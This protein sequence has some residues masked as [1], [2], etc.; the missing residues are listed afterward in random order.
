MTLQA[1]PSASAV[2]CGTAQATITRGMAE[3]GLAPPAAAW[4]APHER[5]SCVGATEPIA[6]AE[7]L[8]DLH[9]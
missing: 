9:A 5:L 7:F 6:E 2:R 1:V 4:P 8:V 3:A